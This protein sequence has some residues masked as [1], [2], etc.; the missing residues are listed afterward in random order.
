MRRAGDALHDLLDGFTLKKSGTH[1][2]GDFFQPIGF[3]LLAPLLQQSPLEGLR[4]CR[5]VN[6][7]GCD[8]LERNMLENLLGYD[9]A[10]QVQL[11]PGFI[12]NVARQLTRQ[13][14]VNRFVGLC[15]EV[16]HTSEQRRQAAGAVRISSLAVQQHQQ[17][18]SQV[19]IHSVQQRNHAPSDA[20]AV[21]RHIKAM[22]YGLVLEAIVYGA[23]HVTPRPVVARSVKRIQ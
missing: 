15:V 11:I 19:S 23:G 1:G 3:K 9:A 7:L 8:A 17:F 16:T 20:G 12:F 22:R 13:R 4:H 21:A 18:G 2:T 10:E 14:S 6:L 5:S